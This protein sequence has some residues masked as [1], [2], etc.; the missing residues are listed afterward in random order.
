MISDCLDTFCRSSVSN[1]PH[2]AATPFLRCAD[3]SLG[4]RSDPSGLQKSFCFRHPCAA[5]ERQRACSSHT[6]LPTTLLGGRGFPSALTEEEGWCLEGNRVVQGHLAPV[7]VTQVFLIPEPRGQI[8]PSPET[9]IMLP[10][11]ALSLSGLQPFAVSRAV[12]LPFSL[13]FWGRCGIMEHW[14]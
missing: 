10:L 2:L 1:G 8:L 14:G 4:R 3:F 13:E 12:Q 7:S 6:G 11:T 9:P 5:R